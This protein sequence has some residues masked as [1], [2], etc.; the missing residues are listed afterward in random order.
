[1]CKK[2]SQISKNFEKQIEMPKKLKPA[3]RVL[4]K[5]GGAVLQNGWENLL[6]SNGT[7]T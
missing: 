1:M 6:L 5:L 2:P 3:T 4:E 7:I